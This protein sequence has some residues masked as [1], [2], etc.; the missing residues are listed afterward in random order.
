MNYFDTHTTERL[1]TSPLTL[2][3]IEKWTNFFLSP[4]AIEL[5]PEDWKTPPEKGASLMINRQLERYKEGSFGLQAI[6]LKASDEFIGMS[7]ILKHANINGKEELEVGYHFFHDH[8]GNGYAPEIA[9]YFMD[10]AFTNLK[11]QSIISLIDKRNVNSQRVAFKNGL[12]IDGETA[13]F[14]NEMYIFRKQQNTLL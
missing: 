14:G 2:A 4:E 5:F 13:F 7:G 1:Y 12:E 6:Y 10:F 9:Q 3:H 11:T 8:W